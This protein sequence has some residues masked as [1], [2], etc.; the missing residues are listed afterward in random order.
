MRVQYCA[1]HR[2]YRESPQAITLVLAP[3]PCPQIQPTTLKL[4]FGIF[5]IISRVLGMKQ[6]MQDIHVEIKSRISKAKQHPKKQ[7]TVFSGSFDKNLRKK[8]VKS[9]ISSIALFDVVIW[10]LRKDK[11]LEK[12]LIWWRRRMKKTSYSDPVQTEV[13]GLKSLC[14]KCRCELPLP[15]STYQVHD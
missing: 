6:T 7:K 3:V 10:T 4:Y 1:T 2:I 9:Y 5:K 12:V 14:S 15:Y 8:L 11:Y 13:I